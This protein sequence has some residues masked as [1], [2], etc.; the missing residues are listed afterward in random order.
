MPAR[1]RFDVAFTVSWLTL[2]GVSSVTSEAHAA[3]RWSCKVPLNRGAVRAAASELR[4]LTA[5]LRL[6]GA[7]AAQ[8]VALASQLLRDPC[9]PLFLPGG[10]EPLR[11]GA[12]IARQAL[13]L[14]EDQSG[15]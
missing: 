1:S 3:P 12:Q 13:D 5:S 9:S 2:A 6:G 7:P 15:D 14:E 4:A 10:P 11:A 8:G